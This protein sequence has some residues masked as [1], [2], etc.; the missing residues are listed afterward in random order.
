M[1]AGLM[2]LLARL[3]LLDREHVGV[4]SNEEICSLALDHS[5]TV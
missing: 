1:P 3:A 4:Y 5:D 2:M